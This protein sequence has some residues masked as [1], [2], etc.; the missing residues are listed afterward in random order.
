MWTIG[1]YSGERC[2]N[3]VMDRR[4]EGSASAADLWVDLRA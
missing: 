1:Y 2:E 4:V 3:P